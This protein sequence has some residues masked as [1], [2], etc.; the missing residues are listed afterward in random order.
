MNAEVIY[1][2]VNLYA[3]EL[4]MPGLKGHFEEIAREARA[5]GESHEAYL[6]ACLRSE[7]ESRREHR[8]QDR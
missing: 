8:L 3:Q 4:K 5:N 6:V 1:A 7:I 2:Q